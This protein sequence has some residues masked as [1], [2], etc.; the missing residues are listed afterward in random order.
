MQNTKLRILKRRLAADDF[1]LTNSEALQY[2]I[3][4]HYSP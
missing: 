1:N 3:V 2:R 4:A